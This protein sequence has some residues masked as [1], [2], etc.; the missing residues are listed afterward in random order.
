MAFVN[1]KNLGSQLRQ[2]VNISSRV[3]SNTLKS[4][5]YSHNSANAYGSKTPTSVLGRR[6]KENQ[7]INS[8]PLSNVGSIGQSRE[9][10]NKT[11]SVLDARRNTN[12][13]SR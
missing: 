3:G 5:M 2:S 11:H 8:V 1:S 4:G 7:P 13:Q 12:T 10:L 6:D 9:D